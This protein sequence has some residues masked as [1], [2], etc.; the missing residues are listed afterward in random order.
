MPLTQVA[1]GDNYHQR[2]L[3]RV[4]TILDTSR[5]GLVSQMQLA[6]GCSLNPDLALVLPAFACC[7]PLLLVPKIFPLTGT[8]TPVAPVITIPT[9]TYAGGIFL[10]QLA[11]LLMYTQMNRHVLQL[12]LPGIYIIMCSCLLITGDLTVNHTTIS[13]QCDTVQTPFI[14]I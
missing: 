10:C 5:A 14:H 8:N 11:H 12:A 4:K 7:I 1:P 2:R 3:Q 13:S 9:A 6:Q